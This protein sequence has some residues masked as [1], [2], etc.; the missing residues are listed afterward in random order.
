MVVD[1]FI[2]H[3]QNDNLMYEENLEVMHCLDENNFPLDRHSADTTTNVYGKQLI[4]FCQ[5]NDLFI[6]SSRLGQDS[7][8]PKFTCKDCSTI[9]YFLCSPNM[10]QYMH[11]FNVLEF[12]P[13]FS[14]SH[15]GFELK[16]DVQYSDNVLKRTENNI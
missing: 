14:D 11:V 1:E 13:L 10:T 3:L 16:I 9:D 12:S 15:Y 4:E 7:I 8:N 5:S 2:S 6:I